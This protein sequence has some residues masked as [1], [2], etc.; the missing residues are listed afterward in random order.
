[1]QPQSDADCQEEII[2]KSADHL[3]PLARNANSEKDANNIDNNAQ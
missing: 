3:D 2:N 1:M